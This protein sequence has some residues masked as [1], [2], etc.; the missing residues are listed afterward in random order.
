MPGNKIN[1]QVNPET[2]IDSAKAGRVAEQSG[3]SSQRRKLIKSSVVAVPALMTLSSGA[4]AAVASSYQCINQQDTTGI[5]PVLGD[6]VNDD[7]QD[8]WVRMPA[9]PGYFVSYQVGVNDWKF[10]G[11]WRDDPLGFTWD[12]IQGWDWYANNPNNG[13]LVTLTTPADI[14]AKDQ[15]VNA[16]SGRIAFYC[17]SGDPSTG[18]PPYTC[19]DE[20]GSTITPTID[21]LVIQ[22]HTTLVQLLAYASFDQNGN[23]IG[24]IYY[25]QA[26]GTA[27]PVTASCWCS[28]DPIMP[29][30]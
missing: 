28:I 6:D 12:Q 15:L 3:I 29:A 16:W 26:Q 23:L 24:L 4:A 9:R 21:P 1:T 8:P 2:G 20:T 30:P 5:D 19:W 14:L 22:G 18:A 10:Y 13:H 25:P 11:L 27:Q 7:P 17:V